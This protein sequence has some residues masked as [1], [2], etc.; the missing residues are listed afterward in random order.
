MAEDLAFAVRDLGGHDLGLLTSTFD[1][2]DDHRPTV[3]FAY[4]I[5]G[6]GLATEGHPNNHSALLSEDQMGALATASGVSLDD[7]WRT[8]PDGSDEAALCATR[9]EDLR[10]SPVEPTGP[11][12]VPTSSATHPMPRHGS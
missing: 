5:K 1:E 9:A 4:T 6:R 12:S 2:I 3:V 8:F 10:R 11:V 7:P